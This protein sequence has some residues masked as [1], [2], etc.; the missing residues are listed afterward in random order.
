MKAISG[1]FLP[2]DDVAEELRKIYGLLEILSR[3]RQHA[4]GGETVWASQ[5]TLAKRYDM[6]KSNMCRLLMGAT[7]SGKVSIRRPGGGVLKYCVE[8]VDGYMLSI[9]ELSLSKKS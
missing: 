5:A 4:G 1:T 2:A 9:S 6:S 7:T 8:E 3:E